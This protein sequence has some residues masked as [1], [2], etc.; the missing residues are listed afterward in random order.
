MGVSNTETLDKVVDFLKMS[1]SEGFVISPMF[2]R[3][4]TGCM[5]TACGACCKKLS[6]NYLDG[7]DRWERFKLNYPEQARDFTPRVFNGAK[8]WTNEQNESNDYYCT[9]LNKENGLCTIHKD[10]SHPLSCDLPFIKFSPRTTPNEEKT[11]LTSMP[12]GRAFNFKRVSDRDGQRS[13]AACY[14]TPFEVQQTKDDIE[15][16]KE[17]KEHGVAMGMPVEK[18]QRAIEVVQEVLDSVESEGISALPQ[19]QIKI[20]NGIRKLTVLNPQVFPTTKTELPGMSGV[21][22]I[23]SHPQIVKE[24]SQFSEQEKKQKGKWVF[25][26]DEEIVVTPENQLKLL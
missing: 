22:V 8:F 13:G 2:F 26:P 25:I 3:S 10:H 17:L 6:L 21:D 1:D 23:I 16:L 11:L 12:Y 7:S 15:K 5:S 19:N 9:Y 14:S 4:F 20:G 18:L 24:N